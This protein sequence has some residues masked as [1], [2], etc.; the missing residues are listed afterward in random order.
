MTAAARALG[1]LLLIAPG[2]ALAE[3]ALQESRAAEGEAIVVT[4]TRTRLPVT[5]LPLTVV[6]LGG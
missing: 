3:T 6:V 5:A 1:A 4:G 2:A